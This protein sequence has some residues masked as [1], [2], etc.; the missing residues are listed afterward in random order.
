MNLAARAGRWSAAHWKTATFGWLAFVAAA[1]VLGAMH[2]TIPQTDAEQTNGQAARAQQMLA[3]A[4]VKNV[5]SENVLVRSRTLTASSPAFRRTLDEARS[6]AHAHRARAQRSLRLRLE[7]RAPR[8]DRLRHP[9]QRRHRRRASAAGARRHGQ[10]RSRASRLHDRRGRRCEHLEGDERRRL[11]RPVARR[12]A[13]AA[14]HVRDPAARVRRVPRGR[15][16]G[17]AGASPRCSPRSGS[18]TSR[19]RSSTRPIQPRA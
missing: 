19:A 17:A 5:A 14:D 7:G 13:L 16:P 8:A 3:A 4:H 11:G 15:N 12:E 2:G 10:A 18:R 6:D 9:R 1:V